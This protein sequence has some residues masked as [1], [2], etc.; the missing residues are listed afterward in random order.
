MKWVKTAERLP[1]PGSVVLLA[2]AYGPCQ[3][4]YALGR[5]LDRWWL[6]DGCG[7]EWPLEDFSHWCYPT[8][9]PPDQE[10]LGG[11]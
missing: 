3:G 4:M 9:P 10:P 8:P 5:L 6:T 2:C 11:K 1:A 7:V